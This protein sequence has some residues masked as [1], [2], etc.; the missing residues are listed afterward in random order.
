[1]L[2]KPSLPRRISP[3][4]LVAYQQCPRKVYYKYVA[5]LQPHERPS[6]VLMVGNA[7][8]AALDRFFGLRPDDR[9][10]AREILGRCLRSAWREHR[11]ADTF[12]NDEEEAA[13]GRQALAL[14]ETFAERFD[15]SLVP[16]ARERWV[17]VRL[18][19]GV[20][21]YGKVDRVDGLIVPDGPD[22]LEV[23][24][25]KTGRSILDDDEV[26]RE[27][28]VQAYLLATEELY[29]RQVDRVRYLYLAH[30]ADARW[31]P[32]R[33]DVDDARQALI[34]LTDVMYRD[35]L[36]EPNPGPHCKSC[37]FAH[38]CPEA[39]RVELDELVPDP[40]LVF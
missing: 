18:E 19:N 29:R 12:F 15:T 24:D 21:L 38:L 16:L 5:K 36:F 13:Y 14:I 11:K 2:V 4:G 17:S 34:D 25:Y 33:D 32:E 3:S 27:P 22:R 6:P 35:Q 30:G 7:I 10:P 39:G 31:Q 26:G 37:A 20:E 8:H 40:D 9:E 23:I 1:L 28:A